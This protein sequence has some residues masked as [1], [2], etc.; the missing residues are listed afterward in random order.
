M[1]GKM[2]SEQDLDAY[3]IWSAYAALARE[4]MRPQLT[5][6]VRWLAEMGVTRSPLRAG[7]PWYS[8]EAARSHDLIN[9]WLLQAL[10]VRDTAAEHEMRNLL[11]RLGAG[12]RPYRQ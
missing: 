1:A 4:A 8:F 6:G 3:L 12:V 11:S 10:P 2:L 5:R 9:L 7:I